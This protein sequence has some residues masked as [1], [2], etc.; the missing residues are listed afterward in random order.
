MCEKWD[1][2]GPVGYECWREWWSTRLVLGERRMG[3]SVICNVPIVSE[4]SSRD[5][6]GG[7]ESEVYWG[8]GWLSG[9]RVGPSRAKLVASATWEPHTWASRATDRSCRASLV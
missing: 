9:V 8:N 5:E 7:V 6:K 4:D 2:D 3:V 1:G